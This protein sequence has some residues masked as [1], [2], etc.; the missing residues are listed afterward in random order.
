MK[1]KVIHSCDDNP[2]YLNF[3]LPVSK[4]WKEKFN[5]T[6]VLVHIGNKSPDKKYGEVHTIEPNSKLPIHTQAQLARIWYPMHEPDTLWITSDIDMFPM[7]IQYWN[8]AIEDW[9][10]DKPLWTNLNSFY[11]DEYNGLYFPICYNLSLGENFKNVLNTDKPFFD[12]VE[13]GIQKTMVDRT[14]TPENWNGDILHKWNVDE[15]IL[16]KNIQDLIVSG[17]YIHTPPREQNRRLDRSYW[18][19]TEDLIRKGH[20]ID[21]H[22]IRPYEKHK[23]EIDRVLELI[24]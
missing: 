15:T 7:S 6:P 16:T 2:Y 5:I 13:Y 8:N 21:C 10:I 20:Y 18:K 14:H 22:S 4:V 1:I 12:F 23:T 24:V 11:S 17:E 9:K 19:Y 3:W